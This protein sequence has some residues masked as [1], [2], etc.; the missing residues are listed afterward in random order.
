MPNKRQRND[1]TRA[2]VS[3]ELLPGLTLEALQDLL[4][5]ANEA[6]ADGDPNLLTARE[7]AEKRRCSLDRARIEIAKLMEIGKAEVGDKKPVR[8]MDGTVQRV[9]AYRFL[10]V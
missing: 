2:P 7:W 6:Y 8:K 9:S 1:E 10:V 3:A 5:S 4:D